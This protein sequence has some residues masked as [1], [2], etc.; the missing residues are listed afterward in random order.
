M[1]WLVA[2]GVCEE[3]CFLGEGLGRKGGQMSVIGGEVGRGVPES[4]GLGQEF[5]GDEVGED[6][7]DAAHPAG[8]VE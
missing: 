8:D 5:W 6:L 3:E 4:G 2:G 7:L 1:E